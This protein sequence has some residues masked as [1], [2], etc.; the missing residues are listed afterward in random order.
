[1]PT[2][3]QAQ[4]YNSEQETFLGSEVSPFPPSE[5]CESPEGGIK[6]QFL[7]LHHLRTPD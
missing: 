1:M 7:G 5:G 6:G 4:K 2:V 3:C